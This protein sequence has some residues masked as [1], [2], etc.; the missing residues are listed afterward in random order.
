MSMKPHIITFEL[1]KI[2]SNP[3]LY[4]IAVQ[5]A[6]NLI[7]LFAD[8]ED[9]AQQAIA[10]SDEAKY[11]FSHGIVLDLGKNKQ[12]D[13]LNFSIKRGDEITMTI[14][15]PDQGDL[16][17]DENPRDLHRHA[18]GSVVEAE[19]VPLALES[20]IEVLAIGM[21]TRTKEEEDAYLSG[22]EAF[23]ADLPFDQNPFDSEDVE[24]EGCHSAW[25]EGWR[26]QQTGGDEHVEVEE[27]GDDET[28]DTE[29]F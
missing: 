16:F 3:K 7:S 24:T 17:S 23:S 8:H 6:R 28:A 1:P 13:K 21:R 20:P 4:A 25:A 11:T 27:S 19:E 18:S 10:E 29:T 14:P 15:N 5:S 2:P 26:E 9:E 22:R 12:T